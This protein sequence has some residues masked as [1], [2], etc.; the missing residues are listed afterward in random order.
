VGFQG[1]ANPSLEPS[2]DD[3]EEIMA[4]ID[5]LQPTFDFAPPPAVPV[6]VLESLLREHLADQAAVIIDYVSA[7]FPN[8]GTNDSTTFFRV[9]LTWERPAQGSHTATWIV[10]RW[11]AGGVRDS[12]LGIVQPREVLAWERGWLRP[13][14]LPAGVVVPVVGARRAPGGR[15]AWLAMVDVSAELS[16]Y[17][18]MGLFGD[19]AIGR[20]RTILERLA[21]F[22]ALWEQPERQAELH[23]CSWLRRPELSL[24]D[25]AP[26]YAHALGRFPTAQDVPGVH[27]P[28]VW[29][30][31]RADLDAF[32]DARPTDER[33]LWE[34]LLVDRRALVAGL[35]RYP[36][37]LLH[38]DLD[39][40]NI[41]LRWWGGGA[42]T[43]SPG[44]APADLV[45]IDWEWM[46]LGPAA[47]D[48]A[49]IVQRLPVVIAPGAPI[50]EAV[51]SDELADHY[52]RHYLAAG[53]RCVDAA[54]WRRSYG[55]AL[56]AQG[57]A[58]MPF[59]HGSLRRAMRGE[60][61]P[62][63]IVGTSE[64]ITRQK[65]RAGLPLMER[66]EQR[67]MREARRWLG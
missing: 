27:A 60:I 44:R 48:V 7:P 6:D 14:A 57:L 33:R 15:E 9:S 31:L 4:I 47:L 26:T 64:A 50:P 63:Q 37:T 19:R 65:L 58:Q 41:G 55:L 22:H 52:F 18:R 28:P 8:Q 21:R 49:N 10:K 40:R 30:G 5:T 25:M 17:P 45:L 62:P 42:V 54:G 61:P 23:V 35:A 66:M 36:W 20:T 29:G 39:D 1:R 56:V 24:W 12:A 53:G 43:R 2:P 3:K 59:V 16:A 67:V 32:L 46:G 13:A 38:N 11:K 34:Q 51:W